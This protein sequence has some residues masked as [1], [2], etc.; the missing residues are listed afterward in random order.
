MEI[1][2]LTNAHRIIWAS[3]KAIILLMLFYHLYDSI[4]IYPSFP[5]GEFILG[6]FIAKIF[7]WL[8]SF[9]SSNWQTVILLFILGY[10]WA[11][12]RINKITSRRVEQLE[13]IAF[14]QLAYF[15]YMPATDVSRINSGKEFI[16][17]MITGWFFS[18]FGLDNPKDLPWSA[19]P[20]RFRE[21]VTIY[22][23]IN[24]KP[25]EK[26]KDT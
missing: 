6:E 18:W 11:S 12:Y 10:S 20:E 5:E 1:L 15:N 22:N 24:K 26:E 17:A 3:I 13:V 14:S 9:I 21:E 19:R 25:D 23:D 16:K 4:L 8:Y 2:L 7:I